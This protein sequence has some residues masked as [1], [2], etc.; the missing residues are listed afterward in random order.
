MLASYLVKLDTFDVIT[1][2]ARTI[3]FN[4]LFGFVHHNCGRDVRLSFLF[5][6]FRVSRRRREMYCGH[7]RLCAV[8]VTVCLF[9]WLSVPHAYTLLH[10][11]M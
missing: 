10:G 8:Y 6:T 3:G 7:A 2:L 5:T 4:T 11:R 9:V 1:C